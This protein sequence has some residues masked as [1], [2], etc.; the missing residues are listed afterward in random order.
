FSRIRNRVK[1]PAYRPGAHVEGANVTGC[2]ARTAE[3]QE[4]L[5]DDAWRDVRN[6]ELQW[7]ASQTLSQVNTTFD[8]EAA[9]QR[10]TR[11]V[12]GEEVVLKR[13]EDAFLVSIGP[14]RNAA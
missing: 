3:D 2:V 5:V 14:I 13:K 11:E 9:D 10:A 8:S 7:I 4:I 6:G 12:H 1:R